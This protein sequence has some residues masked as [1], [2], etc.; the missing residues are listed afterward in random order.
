MSVRL[1]YASLTLLVLQNSLSA[2]CLRY[3]R[4]P[5]EDEQLLYFTTTAVVMCEVFK[6]AI[7]L[8]MLFWESEV[9]VFHVLYEQVTTRRNETFQV[10]TPAAVYAVQNNLLY[11]AASHLSAPSFQVLSQGKLV[12]TAIF[13]YLMLGKQLTSSQWGAVVA[14]AA[15]V[16]VVQLSN[17]SS[18][19]VSEPQAYNTTIGTIAIICASV[20]S[21]FAGVYLEG[22]LKT[23]TASLWVRNVQLSLFGAIVALIG[24]ILHDGTAIMEHG[25]FHGYNASV[26]GTVL[27]QSFGGLLT[28]VVVKHA[29][30]ILKGFATG[31]AIILSAVL[32]TWFFDFDLTWRFVIGA[33][34]VIVSVFVYGNPR[35]SR[36]NAI[37]E[38]GE[39]KAVRS[40]EFQAKYSTNHEVDSLIPR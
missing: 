34:I 19:Q 2:I 25:F 4:T 14:L 28:A 12:T 35:L 9:Q 21:G 33:G 8:M 26:W 11:I 36:A 22:V 7:S 13:S 5:T 6:L 30:N 16:A 10:L 32:S 37:I 31:L 23:T 38:L 17:A 40:V 39:I 1:K 24:M 3:S 27:L 15:G 20:S 18:S 29:D